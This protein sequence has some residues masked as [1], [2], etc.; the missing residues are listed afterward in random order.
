MVHVL[1]EEEGVGKSFGYH[2]K[3]YPKLGLKPAPTQEEIHPFVGKQKWLVPH[4]T[5]DLLEGAKNMLKT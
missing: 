1:K 2:N 4:L 5:F 3:P